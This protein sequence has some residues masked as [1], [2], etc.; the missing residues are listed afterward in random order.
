MQKVA[1]GAVVIAVSLLAGYWLLLFLTQRSVLFPMPPVTGA[2]PRPSDAGQ[3]WLNT[4]F[5]RVEAWYLPAIQSQRGRSPLLVFTHGN[6]ELIDYWPQE[7]EEPRRWGVAVLLV[8]Y[9]GYGRSDGSPSQT[10]ITESM[11]AA[12]DWA[13][14]HED[15]EASRII[16]YGR[17]LGG[18]AASVLS[19]Q[20]PV[21]ALI[22][23]SSFSSVA[24]FASGFGAP[25][26]IV[27]DKFDSVAALR[28]FKGPI[29]ILHGD[30]DD[31]VPPH[32]A[33]TLAAAS[34]NATLKFM[35]CG[36]NDCPRPW[37]DLHAFLT[38]HG[39]LT[40]SR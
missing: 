20:R 27:R 15:I 40:A 32:H 4:S 37:A 3:L 23:E 16:P 14:Q 1:I 7:F 30:R 2:P 10:S 26:F 11:L 25:A 33:R 21:A 29:L 18:G 6:G 35:S 12:Y 8:E 13:R 24:A 38:Q 19:L 28:S 9:P 36:H 17:S 31:L 39:L 22:L 34:G 5:G